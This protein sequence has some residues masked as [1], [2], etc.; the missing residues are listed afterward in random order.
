MV[1]SVLSN[2]VTVSEATPYRKLK[3]AS[4]SAIGEKDLVI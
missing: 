1:Y 2:Y 4:Q 3:L